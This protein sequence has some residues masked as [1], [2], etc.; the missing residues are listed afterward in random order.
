MK[1]I[2]VVLLCIF[3]LGCAGIKPTDIIGSVVKDP[4]TVNCAECDDGNKCTTDICVGEEKKCEYVR[5]NKCCGDNRCDSGETC[6]TCK[7]DCGECYTIDQLQKDINRVYDRNP[8]LAKNR[9]IGKVYGEVPSTDYNFYDSTHVTV[10]EIKNTNKLLSTYEDFKEFVEEIAALRFE[11]FE[12]R[13]AELYIE[14]EYEVEAGYS[15]EPTGS[16]SNDDI[17]AYSYW[18]KIT[19]VF[20]S[21]PDDGVRGFRSTR[22]DEPVLDSVLYVQCAPNLVIGFYSNQRQML[23][24]FWQNLEEDE[25]ERQI[26]KWLER[27]NLGALDEASDLL[28]RCSS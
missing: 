20:Y 27:E 3:L 9:V 13:I 23:E 1:K 22:L 28:E 5:I 12:S 2:T 8:T 4:Q 17:L 26:V 6:L 15:V 10:I 25:Y 18:A 11:Y 7:S 14:D 24:K 19:K 21:E 16:L